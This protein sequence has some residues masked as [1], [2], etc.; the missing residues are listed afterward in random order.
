[1]GR[2]TKLTPEVQDKIAAAIKAG[3]YKEVAARYA[4]I[5]D[6]TFR[7]WMR[8]GREGD[9]ALYVAFHAAIT[10]AEAEA[11][12]RAVTIINKAMTE[13]WRAAIEY[14]RRKFPERWSSTQRIDIRELN[15]EQ[16]WLLAGDGPEGVDSPGDRLAAATSAEGEL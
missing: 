9:G 14:I 12:V 11:E 7:V 8:R 10:R 3:N 15:T 6:A 13:D 16:L 5:D 4:G 2:P 1:M